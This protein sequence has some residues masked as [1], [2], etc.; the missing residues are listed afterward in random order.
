MNIKYNKELVLRV[1]ELF[2]DLSDNYEKKHD[3]IF[4][5]EVER[6][7]MIGGRYLKETSDVKIL[8]IG[9]GTGF[10]PLQL[11]DFLR[12]RDVFVCLDISQKMLDECKKNVD[13]KKFT[14]K[15]SYLKDTGDIEVDYSSFD[16]IT[17]NSVLH[18]LPNI[19]EFLN[20]V[21][22][23]LKKG[24][25]IV[26]GHEPNKKFYQSNFLWNN[27]YFISLV[28]QPKKLMFLL[29]KKLHLQALIKR[30]RKNKKG[31]IFSKINAKLIKEGMIEKEL[32]VDNISEIID[33]HSPTAGGVHR[34]K[35]VD[36]LELVKNKLQNFDIDYFETYNFLSKIS[37]KN[38]FLKWYDRVLRAKFPN[39]GSNFFIVL[40]RR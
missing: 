9:T 40:K 19:E 37:Q 27:Y 5:H 38:I 11:G 39:E 4:I 36:L 13:S 18:H 24:G 22:N 10:I 32:S 30:V 2:H 25:R 33:I 15:F 26:I 28:F 7:K 3:G 21:N 17:I 8:D 14:A 12:K 1:N 23:T 16:I 6:W 20:G 29:L 35:E 34:D 31:E